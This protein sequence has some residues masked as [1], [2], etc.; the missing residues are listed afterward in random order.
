MQQRTVKVLKKVELIIRQ[1]SYSPD[2]LVVTVV[3][4][5]EEVDSIVCTFGELGNRTKDL[6]A[7][8]ARDGNIAEHLL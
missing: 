2:V 3:R 7:Q 8:Y 4:D 6:Y 5:N 1:H